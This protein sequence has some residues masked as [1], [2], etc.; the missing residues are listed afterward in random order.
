MSVGEFSEEY[1][2]KQLQQLQQLESDNQTIYDIFT[3][4]FNESQVTKKLLEIFRFPSKLMKYFL[5]IYNPLKTLSSP[6]S[7]ECSLSCDEITKCYPKVI[8]V[9]EYIRERLGE[10]HLEYSTLIPLSVIYG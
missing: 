5:F 2:I 3:A 9:D 7:P 6:L 1:L 8:S 10:Q 4:S